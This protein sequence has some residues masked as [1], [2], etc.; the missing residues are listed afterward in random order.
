MDLWTGS[1]TAY[2]LRARVAK[3]SKVYCLCQEAKCLQLERTS[4]IN[5]TQLDL[6]TAGLPSNPEIHFRVFSLLAIIQT[7]SDGDTGNRDTNAQWANSTPPISNSPLSFPH[8]GRCINSLTIQRESTVRSESSK[9][10]MEYITQNAVSSDYPNYLKR[11]APLERDLN[12]REAKR[13]INNTRTPPPD[14]ENDI[15]GSIIPE[16]SLLPSKD[17]C[18]TLTDEQCLR[19]IGSEGS[20]SEIYSQMLRLED[21]AGQA[22]IIERDSNHTKHRSPSIALYKSGNQNRCGIMDLLNPDTDA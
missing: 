21:Q 10:Y 11:K 19:E 22:P 8:A 18:F 2:K 9:N 1:K 12:P 20:N 7:G 5:E 4:G 6:Y 15:N 14:S 13:A 17:Q 16:N 3:N